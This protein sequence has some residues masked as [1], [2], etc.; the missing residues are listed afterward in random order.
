M[1]AEGFGDWE[2]VCSLGVVVVWMGRECEFCEEVLGRFYIA[3][4]G[5]GPRL[6]DLHDG[7]LERQLQAFVPTS[8]S[9]SNNGDKAIV[10][11]FDVRQD[12]GPGDTVGCSLSYDVQNLPPKY[13]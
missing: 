2:V 10:E 9:V 12:P 1:Q 8:S 5:Q 4:H 13:H 3:E 11:I 6:R 7:I